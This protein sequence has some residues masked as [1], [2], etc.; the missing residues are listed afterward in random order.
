MIRCSQLCRDFGSLRAVSGVDLEVRQGEIFGLLGPDGAGKTT[1][2][3]LLTGLLEPTAGRLEVL[4]AGEPER[5]KEYFGYVPQRFSLYGDLSVGENLRLMATLYGAGAE[6]A[7]ARATDIL[8]FTQLLPF[9]DRL[10]EQLSGGMKQK[11]ALA[12]GLLHTPRLFFLDEPTT[13]VDPVSRRE[14]WHLLYRLNRE[15]MTIFVSTPYMEE[16]ELCHRVAFL[17]EGRLVRCD[18]PRALKNAYPYRLLAVRGLGRR[19]RDLLAGP[20]VA[21]VHTFGNAYHVAVAEDGRGQLEARLAAAGL[22]Q[23]TVEEIGPTLEDVFIHLAREVE[24]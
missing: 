17:H 18:T 22:G 3:R 10:A 1:F 9:V 5:V 16:A 6:E 8:R 7:A 24:R 2:I 23:A 15:G 21:E 11:L 12:A 13:G 19:E 20:G 14:F 4:G